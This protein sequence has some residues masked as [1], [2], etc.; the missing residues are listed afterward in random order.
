VQSP[1][2]AALRYA[3]IGWPV[4]PVGDKVPLTPRGHLDATTDTEQIRQWWTADPEAWVGIHCRAAGF[5][6][7]DVDPRNGGIETLA[8]LEERWGPLPRDAVQESP[9]GGLHILVADPSPGPEG[10]TRT[11]ASG[12]SIRGKLPGG[13]DI[14]TNGYIVA[15]PS[16]GYKWRTLESLPPCPPAWSEI[17]RK[18]ETDAPADAADWSDTAGEP[19]SAAETAALDKELAALPP[20]GQGRSVTFRAVVTIFHGWGLGVADGWPFLEDWD[21]GGHGQAELAR[22]V[23]RISAQ[24]LEGD[25]GHARHSWR[26]DNVIRDFAELTIP[27]P[28]PVELTAADKPRLWR[29]FVQ[30][31]CG[32]PTWLTL[33]K[34]AVDALNERAGN[35]E[36]TGS[37]YGGPV[38]T[39]A[40]EL[41]T[42]PFPPTN[43]L[44]RGLVPAV[45]VGATSGEPKSC[46]T[47]AELEVDIAIATG[48]KAFGEYETGPPR[49]VALFLAEDDDRSARNRLRALAAG[50]GIEPA[51]AAERIHIAC[52]KHLDLT[53]DRDLAWII[54]SCWALPE[55][56]ALVEID[57]LRDVHGGD[58]NDSQAMGDLMARL[59]TIRDVVGC[60]VRFVH[61][62]AKASADSSKRRGGQQMRGS[63]AIHGAI[64]CGLYLDQLETDGKTTWSS[65]ARVDIRAARGAGEFD[66][67]LN[68]KDDSNDEAI[69]AKWVCAR[70]R[71]KKDEIDDDT[72]G[73]VLLTMFEAEI[74][75]EK[76]L[77]TEKIR[78]RSKVGKAKL[79]EVLPKLERVGHVERNYAGRAFCGWRITE[80]GK[81]HI[82]R[83][84]TGAKPPGGMTPDEVADSI[85]KITEKGIASEGER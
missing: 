64:D 73:A 38:F 62:S 21:G 59:R 54:A 47:W 31:W 75:L 51:E 60:A 50:R 56:P 18:P 32:R 37:K 65:R 76:P 3:A 52:R 13:I 19:L 27:E 85:G 71:K 22:Q 33:L 23:S 2:D 74:K 81:A 61:H 48:T 24:P 4:F 11:Q 5:V 39:P 69:S 6:A 77:S 35:G 7:F 36:S 10:W 53:N 66:L 40:A 29:G 16:K 34:R 82:G 84:A 41:F 42:R 49:T 58:E 15:E 20:R 43:W 9:S 30:W 17:V 46:K 8:A 14:K 12:G 79:Q 25:R 70:E 28:A 26:L 68:I 72:I 44:V 55:T 1:I 45:T 63:G 80:A 67:T 78:V 83:G 57:P